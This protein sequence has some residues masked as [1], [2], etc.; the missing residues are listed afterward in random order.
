VT[1]ITSF[2]PTKRTLVHQPVSSC[3]F[4]ARIDVFL[5]VSRLTPV[6]LGGGAD[7]QAALRGLIALTEPGRD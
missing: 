6:P 1:F 3:R 2:C 4:L 7:A 5:A